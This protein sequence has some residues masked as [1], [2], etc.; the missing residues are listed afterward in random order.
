M[1]TKVDANATCR[2]FQLDSLQQTCIV[3]QIRNSLKYVTW[4]ERKAVAKDLKKIY[5]ASSKRSAEKALLEME[6]ISRFAD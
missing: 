4:G 5:Q 6:E 1:K 3:H 2:D